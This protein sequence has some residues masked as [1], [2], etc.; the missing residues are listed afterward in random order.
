MWKKFKSFFEGRI[1]RKHYFFGHLTFVPLCLIVAFASVFISDLFRVLGVLFPIVIMGILMFL[2]MTSL[3][4]RRLHDISLSGYWLVPLYIFNISTN[5]IGNEIISAFGWI[6]SLAFA[7]I[8][9]FR[10]GPKDENRFGPASSQMRF[11]DVLL[12]RKNIPQVTNAE[13]QRRTWRFDSEYRKP[14]LFIALLCII[15]TTYS[16]HKFSE[17]LTSLEYERVPASFSFLLFPK[18]NEA[19]IYS[20]KELTKL[21]GAVRRAYDTNGEEI[22]N[23]IAQTNIILNGVCEIGYMSINALTFQAPP[24]VDDLIK[25]TN[26]TFQTCKSPLRI[27]WSEKIS[28]DN[29]SNVEYTSFSSTI[30]KDDSKSIY[31]YL[32]DGAS[33]I[34]V[35]AQRNTG[36]AFEIALV[37][38]DIA[39]FLILMACLWLISKLLFLP[40]KVA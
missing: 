37:T 13:T 17:N 2:Y 18:Q 9:F 38:I 5:F 4:V 35:S 29:R 1:G 40:S 19:P 8:M 6:L 36:I 32:V 34:S 21:L 22:K 28:A 15:W 14:F 23:G 31:K 25:K 3:D 7:F 27:V 11:F 26:D 33:L 20:D 24:D 39:L 10:A 16:F 12:N 30:F